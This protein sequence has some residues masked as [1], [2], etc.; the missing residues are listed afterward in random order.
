MSELSKN[1]NPF[2]VQLREGLSLIDEDDYQRRQAQ[3]EDARLQKIQRFMS[4]G[5]NEIQLNASDLYLLDHIEIKDNLPDSF[6]E[7]LDFRIK[8][9]NWQGLHEQDPALVLIFLKQLS[10]FDFK[11]EKDEAEADKMLFKHVLQYLRPDYKPDQYALDSDEHDWPI[12][13]YDIKEI[14]EKYLDYSKIIEKY[15]PTLFFLPD[16][17]FYIKELIKSGNLRTVV[18]FIVWDKYIR[19]N[20][21]TYYSAEF[22]Y[23]DNSVSKRLPFLV[24]LDWSWNLLMEKAIENFPMKKED[25]A[26]EFRIENNE[27]IL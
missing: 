27:D 18:K 23:S 16:M 22:L 24:Y 20:I 6:F 21:P 15:T 12:Y 13:G 19:R 10:T 14:Y 1:T 17:S 4:K 9:Y 11:P 7:G 5:L 3:R 26:N 2:V 25:I 8:R